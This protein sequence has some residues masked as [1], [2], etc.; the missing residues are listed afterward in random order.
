MLLGTTFLTTSSDI[1]ARNRGAILT[2]DF[3]P[4]PE[5]HFSV[6]VFKFYAKMS[7]RMIFT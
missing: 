4:T 6:V 2:E 1:Q 7:L 5:E 3:R